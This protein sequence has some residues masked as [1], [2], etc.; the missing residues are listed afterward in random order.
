VRGVS[1]GVTREASRFVVTIFKVLQKGKFSNSPRFSRTVCPSQLIICL[2]VQYV[3]PY[4]Q[5]DSLDLLRSRQNDAKRFS[6]PIRRAAVRDFGT[7]RD[8]CQILKSSLSTVDKRIASFRTGRSLFDGVHGLVA[9]TERAL[10]SC[11]RE[12]MNT[13]RPFSSLAAS[14]SFWLDTAGRVS[15]VIA[16]TKNCSGHVHTNS[17]TGH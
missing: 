7:S 4:F 5:S 6:R 13:S 11:A 9:S 1:G 14:S 12:S 3:K 16:R 2:L 10:V 17:G 8:G 15:C